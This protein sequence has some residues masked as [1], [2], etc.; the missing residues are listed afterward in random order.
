MVFKIWSHQKNR[1]NH[2]FGFSK[3]NAN[4]SETR[5]AFSR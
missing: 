1:L 3:R 5:L 2:L 4:L